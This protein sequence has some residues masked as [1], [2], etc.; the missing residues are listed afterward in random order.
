M[1]HPAKLDKDGQ[2]MARINQLEGERDS[3]RLKLTALTAMVERQM[4]EHWDIDACQ[5]WFCREGRAAG[6]RPRG[7]YLLHR[8]AAEA[9]DRS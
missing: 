7:E 5:C 3:L 6:C 2:Y 1:E 4:T 8:K 9:A